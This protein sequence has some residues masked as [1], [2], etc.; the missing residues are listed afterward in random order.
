MPELVRYIHRNPVN[1]GMV[2]DLASYPY[3]S[4]KAYLSRAKKW[5]WISKGQVLSIFSGGDAIARKKYKVFV[6]KEDSEKIGKIFSGARLPIFFGSEKFIKWVKDAFRGGLTNPE[7]PDGR[8]L[9]PDFDSIRE[10]VCTAYEA[11]ETALFKMRRG[12]FNEPRCIAIYLAR[13]LTGLNLNE[14]A[15]IFSMTN[16][17]SVSSMT[18]KMKSHISKDRRLRKKVDDLKSKLLK[19]QS[20]RDTTHNL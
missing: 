18:S 9:R 10:A 7:I 13:T 3:S 14:I 5:D 19:R 17:S 12:W 8:A 4:H 20:F 11:D 1:A 2:E 15:E 6:N 16:Y